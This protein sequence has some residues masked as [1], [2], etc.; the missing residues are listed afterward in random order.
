[1]NRE[2]L[3]KRK[4]NKEEDIL[5]PREGMLLFGLRSSMYTCL[6]ATSTDPACKHT[7]QTW[8]YSLWNWKNV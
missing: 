8:V 1:M 6:P 7:K 2:I 5:P 4:H 3:E